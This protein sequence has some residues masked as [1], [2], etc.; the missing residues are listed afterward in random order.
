MELKNDLSITG[1]LHSVDQYLNV[2][3]NDIRV[4]NQA[5]YPH[6]LSVKDCFVRGSV[7]RYIMVS[8]GP[9]P[10]RRRPAGPLPQGPAGSAPGALALS[11]RRHWRP[12]RPALC[13]ATHVH[14]R[15]SRPAAAVQLPPGSVDVEL[16]HD[17]TRREA[18]GA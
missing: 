17:A 14:R 4:V 16:L 3:L 9:G 18:R 5:K 12:P 15:R 10:H 6:L 2:K 8:R 11:H 13:C 1:T 7:V